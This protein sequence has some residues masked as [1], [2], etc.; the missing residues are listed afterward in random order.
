M[1]DPPHPPARCL[2]PDTQPP[3]I[4]Y[5]AGLF[6][7]CWSLARP[8]HPV[9]LRMFMLGCHA[10]WL[11]P[12]E[13]PDLPASDPAPPPQRLDVQ[14]AAAMSTGLTGDDLQASAGAVGGMTRCMSRTAKA[15]ATHAWSWSMGASTRRTLHTSPGL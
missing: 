4:T 2:N 13:D 5:K 12:S 10:E 3:A 15:T 11:A 14:W 7:I 9:G 8:M 6:S 1:L